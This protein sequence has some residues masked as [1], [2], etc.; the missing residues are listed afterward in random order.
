MRTY[1]MHKY[2]EILA[3]D[4]KDVIERLERIGIKKQ[5]EG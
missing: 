4:Y 1:C 3:K 2:L 5:K